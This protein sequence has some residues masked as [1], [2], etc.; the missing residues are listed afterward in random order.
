MTDGG[1]FLGKVARQDLVEDDPYHFLPG[2]GI[3]L[4]HDPVQVIAD[5]KF[6]KIQLR[7]NLFVRQTLCHKTHQLLLSQG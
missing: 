4:L 2:A 6:R 3:D 5:G 1:M 7:G